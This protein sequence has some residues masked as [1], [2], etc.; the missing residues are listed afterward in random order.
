MVKPAIQESP[1][2]VIFTAKV[3]PGSSRTAVAG[4]LEDMVKIRVAAAR[5]KGKANQCLTAFLAKQLGV[6]KN[7]IEI[8]SGQTSPIKQVRV[9]GISAAELVQNLGLGGQGPHQ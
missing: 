7:A 5:E 6:K 3:V 1:G 2:G 4:V 9:A 8:L